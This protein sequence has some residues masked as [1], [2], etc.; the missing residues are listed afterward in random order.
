[1][2]FCIDFMLL[3]WM[4]EQPLENNSQRIYGVSDYS[5]SDILN[6]KSGRNSNAE[7]SVA[8]SY[9]TH[10]VFDRTH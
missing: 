7:S 10:N 2:V 6:S 3:R 9:L 1:M 8:Q 5:G 4:P